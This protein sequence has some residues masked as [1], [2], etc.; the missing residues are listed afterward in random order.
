MRTLW[1]SV[2]VILASGCMT[3]WQDLP[4]HGLSADAG[5]NAALESDGSIAAD[6]GGIQSVGCDTPAKIRLIPNGDGTWHDKLLDLD[7]M[8]VKT[9]GYGKRCLPYGSDFPQ[10]LS[11]GPGM[12]YQDPTCTA[13]K[14][15]RL[16]ASPSGSLPKFGFYQDLTHPADTIIQNAVNIKD[17][18]P[19]TVS[20]IDPKTQ[21]VSGINNGY[22]KSNMDPCRP[23]KDLYV[24]GPTFT[25]IMIEKGPASILQCPFLIGL[26]LFADMP[27]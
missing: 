26:D 16:G 1:I 4:Q 15:W 8:F 27:L 17:P 7:C 23:Y 3:E 10:Y 18:E 11:P 6:A 20:S 12:L 13:N 19:D 22:W 25:F 2:L 9:V 14:V 24:A 5:V 21:K